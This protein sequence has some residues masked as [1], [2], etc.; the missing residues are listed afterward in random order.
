MLRLRLKIGIAGSFSSGHLE[1]H[2][3]KGGQLDFRLAEI[4]RGKL[5]EAAGNREHAWM[6]KTG[7][8]ALACGSETSHAYA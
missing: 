2:R 5:G 4:L 1:I 7:G 8:V 6:F 3:R